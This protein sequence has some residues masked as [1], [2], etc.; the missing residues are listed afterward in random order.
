MI[1]VSRLVI[2]NLIAFQVQSPRCYVKRCPSVYLVMSFDVPVTH[3][4]I[5]PDQWKDGGDIGTGLKRR[6]HSCPTRSREEQ[7]LGLRSAHSCHWQEP[8]ML[9]LPFFS[10]ELFLGYGPDVRNTLHLPA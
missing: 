7:I 5:A 9:A 4:S 3:L 8:P 2:L 6:C 1:V 10:P